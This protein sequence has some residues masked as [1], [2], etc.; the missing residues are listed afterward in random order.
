MEGGSERLADSREND[1]EKA[2]LRHVRL[3]R[4][5]AEN[6]PRRGLTGAQCR[7]ARR[8]K[9]VTANQLQL[10]TMSAVLASNGRIT[11]SKSAEQ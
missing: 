5:E 3:L 2:D 6:L 4:Y 11:I 1:E 10:L 8:S 9:A 7:S